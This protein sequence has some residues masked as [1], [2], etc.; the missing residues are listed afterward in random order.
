[1]KQENLLPGLLNVCMKSFILFSVIFFSVT[2]NL[3]AQRICGSNDYKQELLTAD[4]SIKTVFKNIEKQIAAFNS[5]L[6][7]NTV[8]RDTTANE[9]IYIPVVI[10]VLYKNAAENI[11]DAQIKS[12]IDAL[13]NDFNRLNSDQL[14][15]PEAFRALAGVAKIKF[16]LAQ[17]DPQGKSTTGIDRK[18]TSN[19]MFA[20]DDAMKIVNKGG[21]ASWDSKHYLNIWICKLASRSLGYATPPGAAAD[22]D[23]V[24]IAYDVFGTTGNLRAPFNKGRTATHEVGHWLG[25]IHVWGD[26]ACGSDQ[27]DDTPSQQSYNFGCQ[28]F[29]KMSACSPDKNGD[30][31]MNFMD[32]SDDACMNIFTKGQVKRMRALFA[33]GNIRNEFLA[34]FACD[35]TLVQN[36]PLPVT[37]VEVKVAAADSSIASTR[38]YPNPV[39]TAT[40]IECKA[41]SAVSVKTLT[42]L[43][44]YGVKVYSASLSQEKTTINVSKLI[45]GIYFVQVSDGQSKF[46]TK[47]IKQ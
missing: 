27:V 40:I 12:Q 26:A 34:S 44:S 45:A 11:S 9:L 43:N 19:D 42:I 47:L 41:A 7:P 35:S 22:K 1:M 30:M 5:N 37:T 14:N 18:Y 3:N 16:C 28:N 15:T 4:P 8:N 38:V 24:V 20:T 21:A 32:F 39:Q 10:H 36:G 13:N 23:G 17:V 29:P 31:F 2:L 33:K 25:L 46:T 6:R